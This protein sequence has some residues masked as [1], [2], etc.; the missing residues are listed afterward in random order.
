MTYFEKRSLRGRIRWA[1]YRLKWRLAY[2]IDFAAPVHLDIE[3]N[4]SCNLRCP[5][6]HQSDSPRVYELKKLGLEEI[7]RRIDEAK[8][9]GVL[10]LKFNWRGESLIHSDVW[11]VFRYALQKDF[12]DIIINTN[13]SVELTDEQL[14]ILAQLPTIKVS[15]DS[16]TNYAVARRGGNL[17]LVIRNINRLLEIRTIETNR[18]ESNVTEPFDEYVAAFAKLVPKIHKIKMY[19]G[20][21]Q[22]R[23]H[24]VNMFVG[25]KAGQERVYCGMPSRRMLISG[26][27]GQIFPC[28]V[29][30]AEPQELVVGRR[31]TSL[32]EAWNGWRRRSLV[33]DLRG[34][35]LPNRTC[36]NCVSSDAWR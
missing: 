1:M 10:S 15:I 6:C 24:S 17:D 23:N 27:T 14:S 16:I 20:R 25:M 33:I 26:T 34:G 4:S 18:H 32:L 30:Y 2:W 29:P 21:A 9:L 7:K 13:L 12:A 3:I 22:V 28:C 5:I 11:D 19:N 31:D 35:T 8:Q 36:I